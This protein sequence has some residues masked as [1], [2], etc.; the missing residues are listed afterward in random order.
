MLCGYICEL[1]EERDQLRTENEKLLDALRM[2]Y[3]SLETVCGN[4]RNIVGRHV[5]LKAVE[6]TDSD[7]F[8]VRELMVE[9]GIEV[10]D[11]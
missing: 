2:T 8:A 10:P 1:E 7:L 5:T 4:F 6:A 11:A 9:L 3:A